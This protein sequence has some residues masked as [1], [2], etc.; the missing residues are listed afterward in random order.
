M[1]KV[2]NFEI[3]ENNTKNVNNLILYIVNLVF[4]ISFAS[5]VISR[6]Y[7][8]WLHNET[9]KY[10]AY[11]TAILF[12]YFVYKVIKTKF[13][14]NKVQ[15]SPLWIAWYTFINLMICSAFG[16]PDWSNW[17]A[18]VLIFKILGFLILPFLITISCYSF[19]KKVLSYIKS[20]NNEDGSFKFLI[21]IW[22]WFTAFL[23]L[24]TIFW[25]FWLYNIISIVAIILFFV[26]I[27]FRELIETVSWLWNYRIEFDNHS[28]DSTIWKT[29][30]LKLVSAELSFIV[31]SFLI[32][33]NFINIV[34]PMPIWW[35]DLGSYMNFPQIFANSWAISKWIWFMAWQLFTW[36][37]YMYH[38]APQAFFLNQVWWILSLIAIVVIISDL[39]KSLKNN[40]LSIPMIIAAMFYAMPM[41][42]FQQAKDMKLDP[43]LFFVSISWIYL[44][45]KLF[46]KYLGYSEENT[47]EKW[48]ITIN[49][50]D[51]W[52]NILLYK[53]KSV[54]KCDNW[55]KKLF[56]NKDYLWTLFVIW[57]IVW[58]AFAIKFTTLML[59]IWL[60]WVI[61]YAKLWFSGF[62][63]YF[64]MFVAIFTKLRLWDMM[65]VNYP[66]NNIAELNKFSY[67][68]I[69]I[70]TLIFIYSF[71]KYKKEAF[72]KTFV[73]I[74]VFLSWIATPLIPWLAKN[75]WE[76]PR[77]KLSIG[78]LLNW[79]PDMFNPDY[80]KI[81]SKEELN[82][83]EQS[84][85]T[86]LATDSNWKT[87]NEDLWRYFWYEN[88]I[89]N[90]LKL[91]WNLTFQTNQ[92]WEYTEI[93]Y[94]Y[95]ALIPI[96]LLFLAYNNILSP[97][98]LLVATFIWWFYFNS[99]LSQTMTDFFTKQTLPFWYIYI[100]WLFIIPLA[101]F[102]YSLK[103]DK[104]SQVFKLN[105]VFFA[106]YTLIFV[107]AAYW[108]VWYW[109]AM[110]FSLLLMIWIWLSY[111]SWEEKDE[112]FDWIK[113]F[114]SICLFIIISIYFISSSFPHWITNISQ[115]WFREYKAWKQN[116]EEW[117]FAS[118][119]DYFSI[120]AYLNIA[121]TQKLTED[122]MKSI[123]TSGPTYNLIKSNISEK[124]S[125]WKLEEFVRLLAFDDL[126]KYKIDT[127]SAAVYQSDAKQILNYLYNEVL[128]PSKD[129]KNSQKIYRI[130]TFL[131]YF[132]ADNRTRYYDDSLVTNFWKYFYDKDPNVA[133]DRMKKIWL[134][135][136]L[137]DLNAAT[138]DKDPRHDLTNRYEQLLSTFKSDKLELIQTDSICLRIALE[139]KNENYMTY[140]WVNYESYSW[141]NVI[142]RW[143]KQISCYNH[144]IDLMKQN[145]IDD[146]H[147]PYLI[148][149]VNAF[150]ANN[151][152]TQEAA[153]RIMQQYV[154]HWWLALFRIK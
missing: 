151:V 97:I 90:Y 61:F 137:T 40:H 6:Y 59:I 22:F 96:I 63:W 21:S 99:S 42:I 3:I 81:Y 43:A 46:I 47:E 58:L 74:L 101:F 77:E 102:L 85:N 138:I 145:K 27:S 126:S 62:L 125:I 104:L 41:I 54:F 66:K 110:Y 70:S 135:Y 56:D 88:W 57:T 72:I 23:T 55:D 136:L 128:Y 130:G 123:D 79:T 20:L 147:Y 129:F 64:G 133:V 142:N 139:E 109:I 34:R 111:I 121:D 98:L 119:P 75:I 106:L 152:N 100:V 120:L 10:W 69:W 11:L 83:I 148:N 67:L 14:W 112:V 37:W 60:L 68:L 8:N 5:I 15:F 80:S 13:S 118:H 73:L 108:I 87:Q 105:S 16:F 82:K 33:V 149:L 7:Y 50:N 38:S 150:K 117:I 35:D 17:W 19:W 26:W 29:I 24:I 9:W 30:N 12:V 28:L 114:W 1:P 4:V 45:Y 48:W 53:I 131:T 93:T 140:A 115:A 95:L 91:P 44:I 153:L 103:K 65:N 49:E 86:S 36:I 116:Q 51:S 2:E 52:L 144:I 124:P 122:A 84:I 71:F 146:K 76:T 132:I 141:S 31:I 39:L 107:V 18:I 127:A 89:N 134:K 94:F 143:E 25:L 32:S 113:I 92:S 78:T 154:S